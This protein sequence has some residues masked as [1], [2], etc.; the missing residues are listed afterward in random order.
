M[1]LI[2]A[3]LRPGRVLEV[4]D[5]YK[6]RCEAPGLFSKEDPLEL[7][8]EIHP[9]NELIG[10]HSNTFSMPKVEDEIWVLNL[11]DNPEQLYWFRK[12]PHVVNNINIKVDGVEDVIKDGT[13]VEVLCNR[14]V[15]D[16]WA[17]LY[18]S[19]GSGWMLKN[20]TSFLEINKNGDVKLCK[21]ER[22]DRSVVIN[23][24]K[25]HLGL[26]EEHPGCYADVTEEL[27]KELCNILLE[28]ASVAQGTPYT[29][30]LA[31]PLLKVT[32]SVLQRLPEIKSNDVNLI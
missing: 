17:S 32:A 24:D 18:F 19:D 22:D 15:E 31:P 25:I 14:E 9:F 10:S 1:K 4:V 20:N 12:D 16:G 13:N 29:A 26:G 23:D 30:A 8:P 11:T 27:L 6:V 3:I 2:N 5:G 21:G 7:L 28:T